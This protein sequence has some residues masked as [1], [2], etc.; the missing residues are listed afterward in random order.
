MNR[1]LRIAFMAVLAM[2]VLFVGGLILAAVLINPNDYKP[3]I[4]ALAM[5]ATGKPLALKGDL[6]LTVFPRLS[7]DAGPAEL[8][9]DPS[10]GSAPFLQME[11][12]SAAV[13]LLPLLGGKVEIGKVAVSGVRLKLVIN[14][15]GKANWNS[16]EANAVSPESVRSSGTQ[17]GGPRSASPDLSAIALDSLTVTDS[18]VSYTDMRSNTSME[19]ALETFTLGPVKVGQK[20]TLDLEVSYVSAMARPVK[21]ML[22]AGFTL[23]ASLAQGSP[24]TL[25]GKL[26]E[27]AFTLKGTASLPK[28]G[29]GVELSVSG[30]LA[31]DDINLDTYMSAPAKSKTT[32]ET[33][34]GQSSP[35]AEAGSG[36]EQA[37]RDLLH[38]LFLDLRIQA[39]SVTVSKVPVTDIKA[40][41]KVDRGL[42]VAK[43]VSMMIAEGPLNI[44]AS[45][46]AKEKTPKV[47]VTG[48]WKNAKVQSLA[49]ALAGREYVTGTL[50]AEWAISGTNLDWPL[51]SRSLAGKASVGMADGKIP[52]FALIPS[53]VAGLPAFTTDIDIVTCAANWSIANGI[54]RNDDLAL[55][56]VNMSARGGGQINIPEQTIEYKLAVTL[57]PIKQMPELKTLPVVVTGPLSAPKYRIDRVGV[58]EDTAKNLLDPETRTGK[59]IQ[60]GLGKALDTLRLR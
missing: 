32:T 36:S 49:K 39:K 1:K 51:L 55:K 23:P 5:K 58:L 59:K 29:T 16:M 38:A 26:D 25:A 54:A 24:F 56:A 41:V 18:I 19:L 2:A 44:E 10:F 52:A 31:V 17:A 8:G 11:K 43:P 30:D 33:A 57:P 53:G 9:D 34:G 14:K 28:A 50:N 47:R 45:V 35:T 6:S 4:E 12:V 46:D 27:T 15:Q 48:G 20:T 60:E 21:L 3:Q 22:N 37:I 42:L 40:T 7:I 13:G